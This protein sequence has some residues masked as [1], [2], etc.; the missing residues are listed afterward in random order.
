VLVL[1]LGAACGDGGG[2]TPMCEVRTSLV[3]HDLWRPVPE[4]TDPFRVD[5]LERCR[6]DHH[7]SQMHPEDF[8]LER[9]YTIETKGCSWGTA[10]QP[11]L[12]P[13]A[14]GERLNFRLWYF[15]QDRFEVAEARLVVAAG[16]E[17]IYDDRVPLP[18][19][20]D[21]AGLSYQEIPSPRAI[22]A[23]EVLRFHVSNHGVNTWNLLEV[24]VTRLEPCEDEP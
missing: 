11:S 22:A 5:G 20:F 1:V 23:G 3:N 7:P 24:S 14:A 17:P 6:E 19:P 13:V 4:E 21:Q 16:A 9:S 15:S 2:P 8:E 10:E 18:V 12:I